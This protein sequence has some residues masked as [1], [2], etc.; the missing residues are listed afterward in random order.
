MIPNR[1]PT[2]LNC[3]MQCSVVVWSCPL[4]LHRNMFI[5]HNEGQNGMGAKDFA[6][7]PFEMTVFCEPNQ[8]IIDSIHPWSHAQIIIIV[9]AFVGF[10]KLCQSPLPGPVFSWL[11]LSCP[12]PGCPRQSTRWPACPVECKWS[13]GMPRT[14]EAGGRGQQKHTGCCSW[15]SFSSL[16]VLVWRMGIKRAPQ[17]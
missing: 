13:P 11:V 12:F 14:S 10:L 16:I 8:A 3:S 15:S 4:E 17:R 9:V 7:H 1:P 6:L 2:A 5:Q